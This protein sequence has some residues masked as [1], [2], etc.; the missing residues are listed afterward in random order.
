MN[1]KRNHRYAQN[2]ARNNGKTA[3]GQ[4]LG[5]AYENHES[6]QDYRYGEH[7]AK[8]EHRLGALPRSP[9]VARFDV[10]EVLIH[11]LELSGTTQNLRLRDTPVAGLR[12]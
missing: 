10:G 7:S 2:D 12:A 3:L 6:A 1:A 9:C 4:R 11:Q 8:E 5:H